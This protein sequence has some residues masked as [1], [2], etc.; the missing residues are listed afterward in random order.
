MQYITLNSFVPAVVENLIAKVKAWEAEKR[1]PFLYDK[2]TDRI[3]CCVIYCLYYFLVVS[4]CNTVFK[5]QVPLLSILDEYTT[6]CQKR[7]EEKR[8]CRVSHLSLDYE[9]P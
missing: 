7:E 6:Q 2:V 9:G 3:I 8:R 1:I 5:F 4:L